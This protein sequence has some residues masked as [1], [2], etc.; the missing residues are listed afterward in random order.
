MIYTD[1]I[2]VC[3]TCGKKYDSGFLTEIRGMGIYCHKCLKS[4]LTEYFE[5]HPDSDHTL[6]RGRSTKNV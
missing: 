6:I 2:L 1:E 5:K 3:D 4:A